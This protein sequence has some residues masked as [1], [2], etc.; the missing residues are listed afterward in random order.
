MSEVELYDNSKVRDLAVREDETKG[1]LLS[2]LS[3]EG[4]AGAL[5]ESDWSVNEAIA[6]IASI[7]RH[8]DNEWARIA[9]TRYLDSRIKEA[10]IL[11]G[12]IENVVKTAE[13]TGP[14]GEKAMIQSRSMRLLEGDLSSGREIIDQELPGDDIVTLPYKVRNELESEIENGRDTDFEGDEPS[15]EEIAQALAEGDDD[16]TGY[17]FCEGHRPPKFAIGEG[18]A[19][20][21]GHRALSE[22]WGSE[23]G[24][25]DSPDGD[26]PAEGDRPP[27]AGSAEVV[28]E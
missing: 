6:T 26:P 15:A 23:P 19:T 1:A 4:I 5:A 3:V 22:A 7:A 10:I 12:G 28:R 13:A 2:F 20:E 24:D 8:S 18:L 11:S 16:G 14:R 9:A 25:G 17:D 27:A 21:R